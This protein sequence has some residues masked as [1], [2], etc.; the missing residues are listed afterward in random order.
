MDSL[1]E[2]QLEILHL[3]SATAI[4]PTKIAADLKLSVKTVEG[5]IARIKEKLAIATSNELL[6]YAIK[7]NKAVGE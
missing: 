6:Q 5:Y 3:L 1:S 4:P 7:F 2:R